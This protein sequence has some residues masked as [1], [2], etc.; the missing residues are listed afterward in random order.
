VN[1][2]DQEVDPDCRPEQLLIQAPG[3]GLYAEPK[4]QAFTGY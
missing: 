4:Y 2:L 3:G 1:I